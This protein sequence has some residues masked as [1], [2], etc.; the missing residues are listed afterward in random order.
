MPQLNFS[1]VQT[2]II[3]VRNCYAK[4]LHFIILWDNV[5]GFDYMDD[6]MI[7]KNT[8]GPRI[9]SFVLNP[10]RRRFHGICL[11]NT[12]IEKCA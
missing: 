5:F 2:C 12:P 3:F 1:D 11:L 4:L 8:T 6:I 7:I 10:I 9:Y